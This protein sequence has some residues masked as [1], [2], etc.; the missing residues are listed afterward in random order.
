MLKS[1][2]FDGTIAYVSKRIVI[3]E[4]ECPGHVI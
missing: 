2:S 3:I 4:C 1:N